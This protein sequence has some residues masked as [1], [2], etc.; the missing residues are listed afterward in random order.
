M[1]QGV[2]L[3]GQRSHWGLLSPL[4]ILSIRCE[5]PLHKAGRWGFQTNSTQS[6]NQPLS[7][8]PPLLLRPSHGYNHRLYIFPPDRQH[9]LRRLRHSK[10][11]SPGLSPMKI[12]STETPKM[13]W[14][15]RDGCF[16]IYRHHHTHKPARP[17]RRRPSAG[18]PA[19]KFA[20]AHSFDN[21]FL[22]MG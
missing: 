3:A 2:P 6:G 4:N 5:I 21:S 11:R 12:D 15:P 10:K 13:T 8:H 19:Q 7:R 9:W 14:L 16:E 22:R 17:L 1:H 20:S 18:F